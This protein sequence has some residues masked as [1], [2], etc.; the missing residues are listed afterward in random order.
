M[1]FCKALFAIIAITFAVVA[2]LIG[3]FV[4]QLP[5]YIDSLPLKTRIISQA[6]FIYRRLGFSL[7]LV[8]IINNFCILTENIFPIA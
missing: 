5:N 6:Y 1:S 4:P 2:V 7:V 3:F 8:S